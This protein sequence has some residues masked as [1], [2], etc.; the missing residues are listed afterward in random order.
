M[1]FSRQALFQF[2]RCD[3]LCP[4]L[5]SVRALNRKRIQPLIFI[6]DRFSKEICCIFSISFEFMLP[7]ACSFIV[8]VSLS[9]V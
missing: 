2:S 6:F 5:F 4:A 3:G 1:K 7:S 9:Y 8:D